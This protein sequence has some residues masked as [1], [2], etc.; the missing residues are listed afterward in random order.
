MKRLIILILTATC[1]YPIQAAPGAL[2]KKVGD[3]NDYFIITKSTPVRTVLSDFAANY[4]IPVFISSAI[5]D[6]FS[7]EIKNS[8]PMEVLNKLAKT[9][10]LSWYYDGNILYIYKSNEINRSIITPTY[11]D[12]DSLIKYLRVS[13][14]TNKQSCKIKKITTFNSIEVNGVP[15]CLNYITSLANSLD[16]EAQSKAKNKD[17]VR[18]FKLKYASATDINYKYRDQNVIV[19]GVIS[20]LKTMSSNGSLP[21]TGKGAAERNGSL[22]DNSAKISADPRLNAIVVKDREI[23]MDIYK[24]LISELD[25]EQRQIEISVS[26]IDVD[27]NDL[28]Q[29]G[30][31][32]SGTLNMGQGSVSFNSA[33]GQSNLSSSVI[34][35]VNNFM[36]RVNALQ[37]NSKAKILSQ[38]SIITLNNMQAILDK[39]VTF[40]TKVSG[41]KVASLESITSGTLLRVTPRILESSNNPGRKSKERVRLLLDIQDGNQSLNQINSQDP[42]SILPQVQNSEMTTE[43]T[44][45]AG[46]SLLLGGFIQDKESTGKEGIPLLSDIPLIGHLFS[47]TTSQKHS[48][49]RLFLIKATPIKAPQTT[50]NNDEL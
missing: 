3:A 35:N 33:A 5:E 2:E 18:V 6:E 14:A 32:W 29:L 11:L 38:P 37:Q 19:P 17:V 45:S 9:Y 39:N 49:V 34:S 43:A 7:G 24:Q 44:L 25:I 1:S 41:E 13:A 50:I 40:Y 4:S 42:A 47:S 48:V 22:F 21:N 27:A 31:N 23:T 46:E 16:Q 28:Q 12:I 15:E 8:S 36:I 26:I 30:V 20:I 10:H